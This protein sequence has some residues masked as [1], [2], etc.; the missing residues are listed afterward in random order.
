MICEPAEGV[1]TMVERDKISEALAALEEHLDVYGARA[2]RW[3]E[4]ARQRFEPLVAREP[5]AQ[6]LLAEA[7]ALE[8]LLDRAPV[9][10]GARLANL[11]DRIVAAAMAD[12]RA[13]SPSVVDLRQVR[14]ARQYGFGANWRVASALAASLVLGI[15]LGTAPGIVAAVETIADTVGISDTVDD[16]VALFDDNGYAFSEDLL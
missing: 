8:R 3:S 7:R 9:V 15:Y 13:A 11:S 10:D 16:D 2:E 12:K 4:A 14:R 6:A 5:R 1:T